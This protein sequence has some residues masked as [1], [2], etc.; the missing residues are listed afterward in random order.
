M[1][2]DQDL[3]EGSSKYQQIRDYAFNANF[4]LGGGILTDVIKRYQQ[5]FVFGFITLPIQWHFVLIKSC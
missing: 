5:R 4:F 3:I 1:L 2:N